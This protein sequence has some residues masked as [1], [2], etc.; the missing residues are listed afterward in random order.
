LNFIVQFLHLRF[1][2][3]SPFFGDLPVQSCHLQLIIRI[4]G[5]CFQVSVFRLEVFG[6][7]LGGGYGGLEFLKFGYMSVS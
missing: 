6:R 4:R 2:R 7:S 1:G 5:S 3:F